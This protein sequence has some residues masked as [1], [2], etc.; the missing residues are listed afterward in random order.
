MKKI[1]L[2]MA[3]VMSAFALQVS[4]QNFQGSTGLIPDAS[5][6]DF[7]PFGAD[8]TGIGVIGDT[9][10]IDE[11]VINITHTWVGDLD[12]ALVSPSGEEILLMDG[13]TGNA[14]DN[15]VNTV[16][17]DEGNPPTINPSTGTPWTGV[18]SPQGGSLA[19]AFNG[20][21]G[22]GTWALVICDAVGGD[23][24][25]VTQWSIRFQDNQ[26]TCPAPFNVS[27]TDLTS[28]SMTIN[29]QSITNADGGYQYAVMNDGDAPVIGSPPAV[30][31]GPTAAGVTTAD[32]IG[33]SPATDYDVYVRSVCAGVPGDWSLEFNVTTEEVCPAPTDLAID[34][35]ATTDASISF[36]FA[37]AN[38]STST[39]WEVVLCGDVPF[40]GNDIA[41]G[42]STSTSVT[43]S[44]LN[45]QTCYQVYIRNNCDTDGFST[46]VGPQ[47]ETTL[48]SVKTAPYSEDFTTASGTTDPECFTSE[49]DY[50]YEYNPIGSSNGASAAVDHT[51]G[52]GNNGFAYVDGSD[53]ISNTPG[54]AFLISP[55]VDV[56]GLDFPAIRFSLHSQLDQPA[57]DA[58]ESFNSM[59][60]QVVDAA[61]NTTV[62]S[63]FG[64]TDTSDAALPGWEDYI[65]DL[66]E[67][68][69]SGVLRVQFI[70]SL[71]GSI[72]F[73]NDILIDDISFDELGCQQ[74]LDVDV[75]DVEFDSMTIEFEGFSSAVNG[76]YAVVVEPGVDPLIGPY[77]FDEN[78]AAGVESVDVTGLLPLSC[79]EVYVRAICDGETSGFGP[80]VEFCTPGQCDEPDDVEADNITNAAADISW[81]AVD[82]VAGYDYVVV[83]SGGSPDVAADIVAG[84]AGNTTDAFVT[85]N[86]PDGACFEAYVRSVC[87]PEGVSVWSA[88]DT[89]C[90]DLGCNSDFFDTGGAT[91]DYEDLEDYCV[92]IYPSANASAVTLTFTLIDIE[93]GEDFISVYNGEDTAQPFTMDLTAPGAFTSTDPSG[94]ITVCF[95]SDGAGVGAGWEA[96]ITCSI[97]NDVCATSIPLVPGADFDEG[98][99][100]ATNLGASVNNGGADPSCGFF[101]GNGDG[102]WYTV[103]VPPTGSI[104]IETQATVTGTVDILDTGIAVYTGSCGS[105][106]EIACD[107]DN[108][109]G[110]FSLVTLTGLTAGETLFVR[111]WGSDTAGLFGDFQIAAYDQYFSVNDLS[112]AGFN[113]YPNPVENLLNLSAQ[114][115]IQTVE[116]YNLLGQSV[117]KTSP[118]AL[119]ATMDMSNL[120]TGVYLVNVTINNQT[121]AY[122]VIKQ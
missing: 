97:L 5:C 98:A 99:T 40:A 86:L 16:F 67:E 55:E 51:T 37:T 12:L 56:D 81:D 54:A 46:I 45:E 8:V 91:G 24:G 15:M 21:D 103:E 66:T 3:L 90:T 39:D 53:F 19:D 34:E 36:A 70:T 93:T 115:N 122:R 4:A 65:V 77:I 96:S 121:G 100:E 1:T 83:V 92:T 119:N 69:L 105:L 89:F 63:L 9:H 17:S 57:L 48:C 25:T 47:A 116:I 87:D 88:S 42:S 10:Q 79:Y 29:W 64:A 60:I 35:D 31:S 80:A 107:D 71:T 30:Q 75:D 85:V 22:S 112:A 13:D 94:A 104:T 7:T 14:E 49:G 61:G 2:L 114:E 108:G 32:I 120:T 6:P 20:S 38:N 28:S 74:P 95:E 26:N 27:T 117:A 23:E 109:V 43:V 118:D 78:L 50:V 52:M 76:H 59:T 68:G 44:G 18:F 11:I 72:P 113:F 102:V 58:G 106:T 62:A 73:E 101:S 33:L 110:S 84:T 41:A 82:G 111:V